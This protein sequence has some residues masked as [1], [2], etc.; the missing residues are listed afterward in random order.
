MKLQLPDVTLVCVETREHALARMAVED[1]LRNAEFGDV[2]ILTDCPA[3]FDAPKD[4]LCRLG[5]KIATSTI[6]TG[7]MLGQSVRLHR[8]YNWPDK[9]GWSRSWWFDVPPLLRTA[10]TLN[11][12]WD[13]WIWDISKWS[14]DFRLYDYIGAPWWYTDGMNVG[15]GGFSWVSTRL[16]RFIHKNRGRFPCDTP[17]DDNL[18]CRKYR[19]TLE[20]CGFVW[21]PESVAR[22][23]S[24]EGCQQPKTETTHFGFHAMFNWPLVLPHERLLERA[25]LAFE[26]PYI[27]RPDNY[28]MNSFRQTAPDVVRELEEETKAAK[29]L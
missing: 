26:S 1:C 13:S 20:D 10:H 4:D 2:L 23:F 9:V 5:V 17:V 21:A 6:Q 19:P 15:N 18:L 8:V 22:Q 28:I 16:K 3:Q 27:N 14:D 7:K 25:R 29:E 11:I 24:W 12:Q